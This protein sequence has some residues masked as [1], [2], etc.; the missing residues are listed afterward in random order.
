MVRSSQD[1]FGYVSKIKLS[2]QDC[3]CISLKVV[4]SETVYS[5]D[6]AISNK[7]QNRAV[8]ANNGNSTA[9]TQLPSIPPNCSVSKLINELPS[10]SISTLTIPDTISTIRTIG[11]DNMKEVSNGSMIM[12]GYNQKR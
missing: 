5:Y 12:S 3:P 1:L 10:H 2:C 9:T 6:W 8:H 4:I 11:R 7:E